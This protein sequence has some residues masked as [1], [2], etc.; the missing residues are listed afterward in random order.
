MIA[1]SR[2]YAVPILLTAVA[3]AAAFF[4]ASAQK[5]FAAATRVA[6]SLSFTARASGGSATASRPSPRRASVSIRL[7]RTAGRTVL[8]ARPR[9]SAIWNG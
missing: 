9:M 5:P 8:S 7:R 2:M 1:P 6:P 3:V 4:F